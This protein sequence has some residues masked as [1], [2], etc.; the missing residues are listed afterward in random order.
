M[1]Q[2]SS[3]TEM[4]SPQVPCPVCQKLITKQN[5]SR[6]VKKVH[7]NSSCLRCAKKKTPSLDELFQELQFDLLAHMMKL[8]IVSACQADGKAISELFNPDVLTIYYFFTALSKFDDCVHPIKNEQQV[9]RM[10]LHQLV[11]DI[12]DSHKPV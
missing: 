2:S 9:S 4:K 6:H 3:G 12:M 1:F 11:D 5:I 8:E 7:N 10:I